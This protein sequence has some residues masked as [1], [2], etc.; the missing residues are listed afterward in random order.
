MTIVDKKKPAP[1]L[2]SHVQRVF[3]CY[4][5]VDGRLH[6]TYESMFEGTANEQCRALVLPPTFDEI[7]KSSNYSKLYSPF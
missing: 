5:S 3:Q 1:K 2:L 4:Y 6:D 7:L